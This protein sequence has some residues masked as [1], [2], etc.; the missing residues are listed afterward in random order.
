MDT[1]INHKEEV[2]PTK[3]RNGPTTEVPA[4]ENVKENTKENSKTSLGGSLEAHIK[5]APE[6]EEKDEEPTPTENLSKAT[7][8]GGEM[9]KSKIP[10][11][12]AIVGKKAKKGKKKGKKTETAAAPQA[13]DDELS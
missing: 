12:T 4:K 11:G 9:P 7:D 13:F 6:N 8:S 3:I 5:A 10:V 2:S 1:K